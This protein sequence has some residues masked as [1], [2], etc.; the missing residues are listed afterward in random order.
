MPAPP[1]SPTP[2]GEMP[3]DERAAYEKAAVRLWN[4]PS[5]DAKGDSAADVPLLYP[6]GNAKTA[7]PR[8]ALIIFPGGGYRFLSPTEAFPIAKQAESR[9]MAAFVLQYRLH[10]YT[11]EASLADAR[12]AVRLL[13]ARA[14]EFGVDPNKI[15]VLGFSA[16]GHLGANLS[17]HGDDGN[18]EAADPV[19]R[20]SSRIQAALLLYPVILGRSTLRPEGAK[21]PLEKIFSRPGLHQAVTAKTPPTFLVTGYDDTLVPYEH[22]LAYASRLHEANVRFELHVLGSGEHGRSTRE[23]D[24]QPFAYRFLGVCGVLP[25]EG[26]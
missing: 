9:G 3:A 25:P 26:R 19:E 17:N 13:R 5:P 24:W 15:C 11:V 7:S 21:L 23:Q 16:G 2:F 14:A 22:I 1:Q 10:P 18:A 20:Q 8:P 12:R 4:G 6:V